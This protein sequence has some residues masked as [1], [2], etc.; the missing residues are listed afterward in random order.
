[1]A[2]VSCENM[3]LR[4]RIWLWKNQQQNSSQ[5]RPGCGLGFL[6]LASGMLATLAPI[7]LAC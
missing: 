7:F 5:E 1:M 4:E 3:G 6:G 2:G